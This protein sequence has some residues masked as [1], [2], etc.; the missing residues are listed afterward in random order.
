MD[1]DE[2]THMENI[3]DNTSNNTPENFQINIGLL[4]PVLNLF[5]EHGVTPTE[6]VVCAS[7]IQA[8][9]DDL[10]E[11]KRIDWLLAVAN[12][13]WCDHETVSRAREMVKGIMTEL[14][15]AQAQD[16]QS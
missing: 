4:P 11:A 16:A 2:L 6:I 15:A 13:G 14:A 3:M 10:D 12:G 8:I 7:V 1:I 5:I 9:F